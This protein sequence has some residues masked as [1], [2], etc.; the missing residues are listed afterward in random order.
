MQKEPPSPIPLL[1]LVGI[2]Q[3]KNGAGW[4]VENCEGYLKASCTYVVAPGTWHTCWAQELARVQPLS[5]FCPGWHRVYAA[6]PGQELLRSSWVGLPSCGW[7]WNLTYSGLLNNFCLAA[8]M[9]GSVLFPS[10]NSL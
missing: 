3:R 10:Q 9:M 7:A 5:G 6:L 1:P 4:G 2:A 8:G